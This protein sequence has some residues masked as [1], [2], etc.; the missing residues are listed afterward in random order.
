[1]AGPK[2][3]YIWNPFTN[4]LDAVNGESEDTGGFSWYYIPVGTSIT[5]DVNREM[6]TTSPQTILGTLTALG[7]NTVL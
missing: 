3:R 7:R 4:Q 2:Y 1:M 5:I 6:V